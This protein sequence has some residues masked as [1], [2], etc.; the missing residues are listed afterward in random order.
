MVYELPMIREHSFC[1]NNEMALSLNKEVRIRNNARALGNRHAKFSKESVLKS[2]DGKRGFPW[3]VKRLIEMQ[4]RKKI[5]D[6]SNFTTE[7][8]N[9]F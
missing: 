6:K 8:R 5:W 7:V 4:S 1:T 3:A 9:K 2:S